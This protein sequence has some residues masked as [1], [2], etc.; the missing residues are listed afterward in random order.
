MSEVKIQVDDILK[1]DGTTLLLFKCTKCGDKKQIDGF[2]IRKMGNGTIRRQ[3][4]CNDCRS[5]K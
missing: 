4:Q 3:A 1:V 5:G 2:G